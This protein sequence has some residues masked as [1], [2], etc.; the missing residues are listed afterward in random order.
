MYILSS[1]SF[2]SFISN[3]KKYKRKDTFSGLTYQLDTKSTTDTFNQ[4]STHC[5]KLNR[6]NLQGLSII[7][8]N[9]PTD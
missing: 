3:S 2:E 1:L 4:R 6:A 8:H 5:M 9:S 7:I